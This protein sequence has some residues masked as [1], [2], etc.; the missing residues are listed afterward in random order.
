MGED[1]EVLSVIIPTH[2]RAASVTRLAGALDAMECSVPVETIFVLDGCADRTREALE[3]LDLR[4]PS[5]VVEIPGLGAAAARNRGAASAAGEVLL[6]VDDDV[7]P[8]PGMLDAHI[9]CHE[10]GNRTAAVGSYPYAP[11]MPVNALD[12]FIREWWRARFQ[13]LSC[14]THRFTYRDCLAGNFS[15]SRREFE[16]VGGFDEEF[17][18]D[19]R[20]DYE[21]GARLLKSGVRMRF[22]PGALAYHYPA[23][24]PKSLL[25]KWYTFGRADVLFARK[26]PEVFETL[27]I[28]RYWRKT[29]LARRFLRT[30]AISASVSDS[31]V[32][33]ILGAFFERNLDRLW[34][35]RLLGM[36]HLS[37][38]FAYLLGTASA[39]GGVRRLGDFARAWLDPQDQP[40]CRI[41][42]ERLDVASEIRE[43]GEVDRCDR[44]FV[45]P[46]VGESIGTWIEIP[47]RPGQDSVP[48]RE[49]AGHVCEQAGWPTWSSVAASPR[50]GIPYNE[51]DYIAWQRLREWI[52]SP[53]GEGI[54]GAQFG[55]KS[56]PAEP[57]AVSALVFSDD[58]CASLSIRP[59]VL[60]PGELKRVRCDEDSVRLSLG[61]VLSE[62]PGEFV[63]ILKSSDRLDPGWVRTAA[64]HF[65]DPAVACVITPVILSDVRTR[66]QELYHTL[67]DF[68]RVR[69]WHWCCVSDSFHP[70]YILSEFNTACHRLVMSRRALE[71]LCGSVS[72]FSGSCEDLASEALYALLHAYEKVVFE[73][74][75]LVWGESPMT[76]EAVSEMAVQHITRVCRTVSARLWAGNSGR[77][78]SLRVLAKFMRINGRKFASCARGRR[79]WPLSIAAAEALAAARGLALG[80]TGMSSRR[81]C[82]GNGS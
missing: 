37:L 67:V 48:A 26:H 43:I 10:P 79:D 78:R 59:S 12:F 58:G 55:I 32:L 74:R 33:A 82:E 39:V 1:E 19:G 60:N 63:A 53:S 16:A 44:L 15:V 9:A 45:I 71:S 13:A 65:Q 21:L 5:T 14:P 20:E 40:W 80:L 22:A 70:G 31:A 52:Q 36:W 29:R 18:K 72:C 38:S 6:F 77:V 41:R 76:R 2:N 23:N 64:R 25:R 69:C 24:T 4:K 66:T 17:R 8:Q 73:P 27:P 50:E 57:S 7:V 54:P 51:V 68:D 35:Y 28:R 46:H 42:V 3:K 49:I 11:E 56:V 62:C 75:A 34:E 61:E 81:W 30:L 47:C